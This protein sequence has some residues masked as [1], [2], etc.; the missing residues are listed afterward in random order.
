MGAAALGTTRLHKRR[1]TH[2]QLAPVVAC[3]RLAQRQAL[4]TLHTLPHTVAHSAHKQKKPT[5]SWSSIAAS[6]SASRSAAAAAA[7]ADTRSCI[8]AQMIAA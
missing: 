8:M 5:C 1:N 7:L 4:R 6:R 3:R 2:R